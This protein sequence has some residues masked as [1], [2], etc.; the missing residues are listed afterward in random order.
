MVTPLFFTP[1]NQNPN[2]LMRNTYLVNDS[3]ESLTEPPQKSSGGEPGSKTGEPKRKKPAL[4]GMGVARLE[5]LRIEEE[6]KNMIEAQG[7]GDTLAASPNATPS[8]DPGVVL[9]GFPSYGTGGPNTRSMFLGGGVGSGQIPVYPPWGFVEPSSIPNPQVYNP[10]NNH[11]DVCF[12]KQRINEDQHVVRSNGGGFS[13]YT[14]FPHLLPPD[15]RSQGFFYDHR[16]ARY[17][18]P[19][20]APTNQGSMEELWSGNPRNETGDVKEYDF[21]PVSSVSTSVGDCSPNTSTI[22]LTLKL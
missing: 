4:R 17:S 15:Q 3:S 16:I 13:E 6:K 11:C 7:G 20:S 18:A 9:Q 21:F 1:T 19:T 5:R 8:P 12:K 10:S 2:E 14:V 22:D